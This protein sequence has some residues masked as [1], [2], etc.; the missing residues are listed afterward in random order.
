[1]YVVA[2]YGKCQ[3]NDWLKDKALAFKGPSP[4]PKPKPVENQNKG[5]ES[6]RVGA[7]DGGWP[8]F[9]NEKGQRQLKTVQTQNKGGESSRVGAAAGGNGFSGWHG[10]ANQAGENRTAARPK[11]MSPLPQIASPAKSNKNGQGSSNTAAAQGNGGNV[12]ALPLNKRTSEQTGRDSGS[13]TGTR[14]QRL[15]QIFQGYGKRNPATGG[16]LVIE[17]EHRR[18]DSEGNIYTTTEIN[19]VKTVTKATPD[20]KVTKLTGAEVGKEMERVKKR[21]C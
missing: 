13:G 14:M 1:V 15:P 2:R 4:K 11:F 3:T 17:N 19:G 21:E 7:T 9:A 10:F 12:F 18:W 5:G 20:G 6:S 8:A 16:Y